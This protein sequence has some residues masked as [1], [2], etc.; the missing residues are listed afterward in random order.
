[1]IDSELHFIIEQYNAYLVQNNINTD[2]RKKSFAFNIWFLK[3]AGVLD[4]D[5]LSSITEWSW[6]NSADSIFTLENY[7]WKT[8]FYILQSKWNTIQRCEENIDAKTFNWI[9]TE[10][11]EIKQ[12]KKDLFDT[13]NESFRL[14]YQQLLNHVRIWG[15]INFIILTFKNIDLD[16][17]DKKRIDLFNQD[18]DFVELLIFDINK[19]KIDYID[20]QYK[21]FKVKNPLISPRKPQEYIELNPVSLNEWNHKIIKFPTPYES[22]M[23]FIKPKEIYDL[24]KKYEYSIFQDNIRNPLEQS[25]FNK[26]IADTLK[27]E[28]QNFWYYNNWITWI[29]KRIEK[30]N[31]ESPDV[32]IKIKWLQIINWAQTFKT[33][34]DYYS[35]LTSS[36]RDILDDNVKITFRIINSPGDIFDKNITKYTNSQNTVTPRDF[37]SNDIEQQ[38]LQKDFFKYTNIWYETRRG[39]FT[40]RTPEWIYKIENTFFAQVYLAFYLQSPEKA[41]SQVGKIFFSKTDNGFYEDIFNKDTK[42]TDLF[43]ACSIYEFISGKEREYKKKYN[44]II[45]KLKKI[46][47]YEDVIDLMPEVWNSWPSQDEIMELDKAFVFHSSYHILMIYKSFLDVKG[48]DYWWKLAQWYWGDDKKMLA[49]LDKIYDEI[50]SRM[51]DYLIPE[52]YENP[53]FTLTKYFKSLESTKELKEL[54]WM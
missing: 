28:P 31:L 18:K 4:G 38:R 11:N 13:R 49:E 42:Y 54:F 45:K 6:D 14:K 50:I 12:S 33:I 5:I 2:E 41:K 39:E 9:I 44:H 23:F 46:E 27:D 8:E 52:K 21:W 16:T 10:F 32:T 51:K 1:M 37:Y 30:P 29:A 22:Y 40:K 26:K 48:G 25:G 15:K 47:W 19:L 43:I 7:D 34:S 20:E 36:D 17:K 53:W 35:N 24:F 3:K